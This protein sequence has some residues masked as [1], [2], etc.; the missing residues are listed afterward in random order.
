MSRI[1][2]GYAGKAARYARF[3]W[4]YAPAAIAQVVTQAGLRP[5]DAVA[6]IGAGP[7]TLS[8]WLLAHGLQVWA[9]EPET[10]MCGVAQAALGGD[11]NYHGVV[12]AA[13]ATGLPAASLRLITVGRALHWFSPA[14]TRGEFNR[15]LVP[16]GW[17]AVLAVRSTDP[18][19]EAAVKGLATERNGFDPARGKRSRPAVDLDCYLRPEER[20]TLRVPAIQREEWPAFIG[21]LSTFSGAPD[22]DTPEFALLE[23]AAHPVF[24]RFAEDDVLTIPV[25]TVVWMGRLQP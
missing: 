23:K 8:R 2:S 24:E 3:R 25:E 11:T 17:L 22:P 9:V 16:D 10:G 14:A 20:V 5:G 1:D 15:I 19:L 13:E 12:A 7:G 18:I 4:D 6:D 21:R